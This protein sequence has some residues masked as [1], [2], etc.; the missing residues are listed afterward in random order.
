MWA[1]GSAVWVKGLAVSKVLHPHRGAGCPHSLQAIHPHQDSPSRTPA[2][3]QYDTSIR[4]VKV[5]CLPVWATGL[6]RVW[7]TGSLVWVKGLA[8]C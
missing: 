5:R 7:A 4:Q 1:T 3:Q 8:V 2:A 6:Q